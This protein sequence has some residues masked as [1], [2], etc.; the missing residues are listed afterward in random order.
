VRDLLE[1]YLEARVA[2]GWMPGAVWRV[3]GPSGPISRG[4]VGSATIEP[5]PEETGESTPYDLASL[6][7]P[8]ATALLLVLFEQERMLELTAPVA[9]FLPEL[10]SAPVGQS[11]LLAL[12]AHTSGLAA[13]SPLYL[14]GSSQSDYVAEI[15]R[16]PLVCAPGQ[17]LYSDLGYILLGAVLERVARARLDRLFETRIARPLALPRLGFATHAHRF[18]DAAAT[19][20]GNQH[21]R[22]MA[23]DAGAGYRWRAHLL[24]GEAHDLNAFALQGIAGHAG[25]FGTAEEV[26]RVGQEMLAPRSLPLGREARDR[27]LCPA[28]QNTTRTVGMVGAQGSR[29]GRGILPAGAP[30]HTGFTGTSLWLDPHGQNVFVLLTNRVH[31]RVA[32]REFQLVRRGFHRLALALCRRSARD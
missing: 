26:V 19:E 15:A 21:E 32:K 22:S 17:T 8:L 13:W 12:A 4:S 9:S 27:L 29:A 20:A 2:E 31:P 11:S 14:R 25:L 28:F 30:G 16:H 23:G 3:E 18:P 6:T 24:R 10:A 1:R 5:S 7:K